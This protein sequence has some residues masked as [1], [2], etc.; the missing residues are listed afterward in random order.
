MQQTTYDFST[1]LSRVCTTASITVAQGGHVPQY[2]D[3]DTI[4][5]VPHYLMSQIKSG[6]LL[7][8]FA[9]FSFTKTYF[10]LML[11]K[12]LQLLGNFIPRP[13]TRAL[14]LDPA[15]AGRLPSP[16]FPAMSPNYRNSSTP[17]TREYAHMYVCA[18]RFIQKE[19]SYEVG[20]HHCRA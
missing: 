13:P 3:G 5:S 1:C 2:L 16:R 15:G 6:C 8:D 12:K 17:M 4:T 11:T 10:T 7:V 14:P 19:S 18:Q 20:T 9:A